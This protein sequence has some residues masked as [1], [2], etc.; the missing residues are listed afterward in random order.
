MK[1]LEHGGAD[2]QERHWTGICIIMS[3]L[4]VAAS[5]KRARGQQCEIWSK[6]LVQH[7]HDGNKEQFMEKPEHTK[8]STSKFRIQESWVARTLGESTLNR[9]FCTIILT[10][11]RYLTSSWS[12]PFFLVWMSTVGTCWLAPVRSNW[13]AFWLSFYPFFGAFCHFPTPTTS[14]CKS[15]QTAFLVWGGTYYTQAWGA[16]FLHWRQSIC[17]ILLK[18]VLWLVSDTTIHTI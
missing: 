5:V 9:A 16:S 7:L 13:F 15:W 2:R 12:I 11:V 14:P 10:L 4:L 6:S 17:F 18:T 3:L 8:C 1:P